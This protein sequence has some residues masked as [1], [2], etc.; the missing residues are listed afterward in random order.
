MANALLQSQAAEL[1]GVGTRRLQ[2][3]GKENN[4]PP[5]NENGSYPCL[6]YGQWMKARHKAELGVVID[7]E[8]YD[9]ESERA[10]LTHH[11]ANNAAID[12]QIKRGELIPAEIVKS[13]WL[14][15]ITA[16][17]A[18]LLSAPV[19]LA[20]QLAELV[21]A[22]EVELLLVDVIREALAEISDYDTEQY[23]SA[24]A[25]H[26]AGVDAS[27]KAKHKPVGRRNTKAKQRGKRGAGPVE[28]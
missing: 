20:P 5:Q 15:M 23:L 13:V 14:G 28:H 2:Y 25:K 1:I 27:A 22:K 11:Q 6:E 3:I 16:C 18:K 7:G 17:R 8:A 21:D 4:P 9:Y 26:L 24:N 10:R 12:E 19:K